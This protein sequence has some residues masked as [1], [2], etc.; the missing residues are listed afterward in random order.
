MTTQQ[1]GDR[2]RSRSR[3]RDLLFG[4]VRV[5]TPAALTFFISAIKDSIF[6]T[7]PSAVEPE[8][9][10][11]GLQQLAVELNVQ[12]SYFMAVC[13]SLIADL[14][15]REAQTTLRLSMA[16]YKLIG[17]TA[18]MEM[19][20]VVWE[21]MLHQT[22]PHLPAV[23]LPP[24]GLVSGA[25]QVT[26]HLGVRGLTDPR[27]RVAPPS[28]PLGWPTT[29]VPLMTGRQAR[30]M[31]AELVAAFREALLAA[32]SIQSSIRGVRATNHLELAGAIAQ[33]QVL[34]EWVRQRQ[35][36]FQA[37]YGVGRK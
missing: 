29:T 18:Q 1:R 26:P 9:D 32:Q 28:Q 16:L 25:A 2:S 3:V 12:L 22:N 15:P 8:P 7:R 30:R 13:E 23:H 27:M 36:R 6:R 37:D 14:R 4:V 21:Q 20:L 35:Q 24:T 19:S 31:A 5:T 10:A 33:A 17:V 34:V 11:P